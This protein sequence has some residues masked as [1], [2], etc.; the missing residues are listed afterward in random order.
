MIIS[1]IGEHQILSKKDKKLL[2]NLID[3][4]ESPKPEAEKKIK[5]IQAEVRAVFSE[6]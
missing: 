2:L 1:F 4:F 3:T 6:A 5:Q